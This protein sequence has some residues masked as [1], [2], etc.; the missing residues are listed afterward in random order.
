MR[1]HFDFHRIRILR[2]VLAKSKYFLHRR[3]RQNQHQDQ[4]NGRPDDL[5][6]MVAFNLLRNIRLTRLAAVLDP[7]V[8]GNS[9]NDQHDDYHDRNR[10][11]N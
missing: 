10:Q 1:S 7:H 3:N 9:E 11:L 6:L 5:Q 2:V 8:S 4:R